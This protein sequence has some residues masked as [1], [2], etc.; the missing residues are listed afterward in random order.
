[1]KEDPKAVGADNV[2]LRRDVLGA[3]PKG[4][5]CD[6]LD[7]G[8]EQTVRGTWSLPVSTLEEQRK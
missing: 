4:Q 2:R 1:M 5:T 8:L 6:A 7:A 3:W